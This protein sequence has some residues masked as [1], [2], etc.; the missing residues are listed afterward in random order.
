M[1]TATAL[2]EK[3]QW[4]DTFSVVSGKNETKYK[5]HELD[6]GT[7]ALVP[8]SV[9]RHLAAQHSDAGSS[10]DWGGRSMPGPLCGFVGGVRGDARKEKHTKKN[11]TEIPKRE[12]Q[13]SSEGPTNITFG[14]V[15]LAE[16]GTTSLGSVVYPSTQLLDIIPAERR[17]VRP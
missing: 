9:G 16:C 1:I 6:D 17:L 13:C 2:S 3:G 11:M 12:K 5:D 4:R 10:I 14:F 15:C 8:L 7:K